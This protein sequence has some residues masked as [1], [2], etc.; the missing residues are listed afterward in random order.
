MA[1]TNPPLSGPNWQLI[2]A[3]GDEFLLSL[4]QASQTVYIA[5]GEADDSDSDSD[6]QAPAAD[7]LGH[8][9]AS[10][11]DS[12]NRALIGPGPVFCRI[13]DPAASVAVALTA[14]TPG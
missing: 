5:V 8:P 12:I 10:G 14:W 2:V 7:L 11:R 3:A 13:V 6:P 9:L 4:P 1:T